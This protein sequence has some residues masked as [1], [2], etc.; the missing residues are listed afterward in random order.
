MSN[1]EV[2]GAE[3]LLEQNM[4]KQIRREYG[5]TRSIREV[6]GATAAFA[7]PLLLMGMFWPGC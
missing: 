7:E 6:D 1:A 5:E 3:R 2:S 4:G